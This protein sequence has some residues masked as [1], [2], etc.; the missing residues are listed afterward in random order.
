MTGQEF[1]VAFVVSEQNPL[2]RHSPKSTQSSDVG[3]YYNETKL[4]DL[5]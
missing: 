4:L 3:S 1:H 5:L 2:Q